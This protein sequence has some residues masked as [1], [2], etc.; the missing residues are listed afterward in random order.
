MKYLHA[1]VLSIGCQVMLSACSTNVAKNNSP[2][3][4]TVSNNII[5]AGAD[6]VAVKK[7]A[8]F[9]GIVIA[10]TNNSCIDQFNFIRGN[11]TDA[12]QRYSSDYAKIGE[13]YRFLNVNKNIMGK[14]AKDVYTLQLDVKLDALCAKVHYT[15]YQIVKEKMK[16]LASI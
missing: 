7:T 11:N 13:G 5:K 10:S 1:I 8:F 3:T 12:Y 16:N 4:P 9:D 6:T 2:M 14:E 15:S